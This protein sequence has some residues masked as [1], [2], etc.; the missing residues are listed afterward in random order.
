[1]QVSMSMFTSTDDQDNRLI[2]DVPPMQPSLSLVEIGEPHM[3]VFTPRFRTDTNYSVVQSR[4]AQ[5]REFALAAVLI[6]AVCPVACS[7]WL[8]I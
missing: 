5:Q 6:S 2:N 3:T 8:S 7:C 1:M 4:M